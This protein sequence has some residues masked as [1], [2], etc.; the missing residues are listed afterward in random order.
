MSDVLTGNPAHITTPLSATV[1]GLANNG[2]G[3]IRVNTLAAHL[4]GTSDNVNV[5]AGSAVNG[6]YVISVIDSTHF[7]L[8]GSTYVFS[9]SGTATDQSLTPQIL[10]PTDGDTFSQQLSGGL[11]AIQALCDRTQYLQQHSAASGG[12]YVA[13]IGTAAIG[14]A[15]WTGTAFNTLLGSGPVSVASVTVRTGD[16]VELIC[17]LNATNTN[18]SA[19]GYAAAR[20]EYGIGVVAN[21]IPVLVSEQEILVETSTG[22]PAIISFPMTAMITAPAAGTF[23]AYVNA[24]I[25]SS[26]QGALTTAGLASSQGGNLTYKV[27]RATGT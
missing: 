4:F 24:M 12:Y 3:A 6:V 25:Q 16:I 1:V 27:W 10:V 13:A 23:T 7:D 8:V 9:A 14:A 26:G 17:N 15:S 20:L 11:S 18:T 19:V 5:V 2:S 22:D 21:S